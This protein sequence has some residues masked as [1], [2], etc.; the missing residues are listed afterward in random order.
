MINSILV[1][2]ILLVLVSCCTCDFNRPERSEVV[3]ITGSLNDLI[4][5]II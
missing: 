1:I 4:L 2:Y 5:H 3:F